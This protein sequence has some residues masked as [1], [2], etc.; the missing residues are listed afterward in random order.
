VSRSP[1]AAPPPVPLRALRARAAPPNGRREATRTVAR[2][3]RAARAFGR[4][5]RR[6]RRGRGAFFGGGGSTRQRSNL[7]RMFLWRA[8][9]GVERRAVG[10][11]LARA[12]ASRGA[13]R[14][15]PRPSAM[16]VERRA[17]GVE[18][19]RRRA[20]RGVGRRRARPSAMGVESAVRPSGPSGPGRAVHHGGRSSRLS[21]VG[22]PIPHLRATVT[23]G[24]DSLR[25]KHDNGL[26]LLDAL[27]SLT[28]KVE[29]QDGASQGSV[30]RSGLE[31][32]VW[33]AE[34][35][36]GRRLR[37][38]CEKRRRGSR[39]TAREAERRRAARCVACVL[40]GKH[41]EF[42]G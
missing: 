15:R 22:A 23:E 5:R 35:A 3:L 9:G 18:L 28:T 12:R 14:G 24:S 29:D 30:R 17:V 16:G 19:A 39:S 40:W 25:R 26:S 4:D 2:R 1:A 37:V 11:E 32:P 33:S 8:H 27:E 38:G 36:C 31:R 6:R 41:G 7:R 20:S 34:R 21:R 13:V 10:V 42:F